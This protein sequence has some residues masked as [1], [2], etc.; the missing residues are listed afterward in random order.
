[1][2]DHHPHP[3]H[4]QGVALPPASGK[5]P[6][7][8]VVLLHGVGADAN[9]LIGLAPYWAPALPETEFVSPNAPFPYDMAPMG[10]QWF[11]LQDRSPEAILAGI[12]EAAP[13]LDHFLDELLA[14]RGLDDS[15][16]ALVGFSQGTMMSLY[17]GLRR[18]R[19]PAC[20]VGYSGA[21]AGA[22]RLAQEIRCR[23]P[24]LLVHGEDDPLVPFTSLDAAVKTLTANGVKV[25]SLARPGLGHSIDE[26]GLKR[27]GEFLTAALTANAQSAR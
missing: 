19:A 17:C 7:S 21:L 27:G 12:Q 24:V 26:E 13:I 9:D 4:L 20:I 10:R 18:A 16:L 14:S 11:S 22:A 5:P 8:V 1:M 25:E 3:P 2:A 6:A 23:P 15:R